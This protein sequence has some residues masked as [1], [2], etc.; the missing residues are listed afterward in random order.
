MLYGMTVSLCPILL[1]TMLMHPGTMLPGALPLGTPKP[2][3]LQDSSGTTILNV[4]YVERAKPDEKQY[5]DLYVPT[6]A[7]SYATVVWFHGG[8]LT[9]GSRG[10]PNALKGKGFAVVAPSYRLSPAVTAPAYIEDAAAAIAWTLKNIGQYGGD[11]RKVV[12]SGH[13]AGGYLSMMVAMD[14]KWL[15]ALG[16]DSSEIAGLVPFSGQC[17]THFTIR[18]E[19]GQP[20]T[21]PVVDEYAPLYH[22]KKDLPPIMLITGDREDELL[23]R[24]EENAYLWRMLKLVGH[25]N[26]ALRELDG[27]NH[28]EMPE[29]AFPLL[30]RFT[31]AVRPSRGTGTP[32]LPPA[33]QE[34]PL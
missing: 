23:G 26:V 7:K 6:N 30:V 22:V 18:K 34:P 17:I 21:L 4:P 14:P 20:D 10:I 27:F 32:P 5:L 24:Y 8:G 33:R 31:Q 25:T 12:L 2:A 28:G 19:R 29:P 3:R 11:R 13:S 9:G 15:K 16:E 1:S